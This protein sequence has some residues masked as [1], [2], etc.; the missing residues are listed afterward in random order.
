M[1]WWNTERLGGEYGRLTVV[2]PGWPHVDEELIAQAA[3]MFEMFAV[4]IRASVVPRLQAR[5][6]ALSDV[7]D[8]AGSEAAREEI[9]A[10]A[11]KHEANAASAIDV[12][13]KLRAMESS[14]VKTKIVALIT[15]EQA[16]KDCETIA[17]DTDLSAEAKEALIEARIAGGLADNVRLVSANTFELAGNLG[18][19]PG[20]LGVDGDFQD[21]NKPLVPAEARSQSLNE[22]FT[23]AGPAPS[24]VNAQYSPSK[25]DGGG[26]GSG[27]PTPPTPQA[28][29]AAPLAPQAE[30]PTAA[31]PNNAG[32]I[33]AGSSSAGGGS[34]SGL[35]SSGSSPSP[36]SSM[37]SGSSSSGSGSPGAG[38]Q[39]QVT[40]AAVAGDK[41][42]AGR[43]PAGGI[44]PAPSPSLSAPA[45]AAQPAASPTLSSPT[46]STA[47]PSAPTSPSM[48]GPSGGGF[49]G[50]AATVPAGGAPAAGASPMPLGPPT[51]PTPATPG[52]TP[53]GAPYSP[54]LAQA[55]TQAGSAV[56]AAAAVPVSAARAERDAAVAASTAGAL[57]RRNQGNDPAQLARRIAAALNVGNF[58]F[59]F[60]WV[61]A[62]T[63][64]GTILVA[65]SYGIGYIPANVALP[66]GVQMVSADESIPAQ[67]RAAWATYPILAL[68]GWAQHHNER[69]RGVIATEDQFKGFD[70]GAAK[71]VLQPEDIPEDGTMRGRTRLEVIAPQA[72]AKLAATRD[73]GLAA[74][75]PP[76]QT[77]TDRPEGD[78]AMLWFEV[79]KP[80]MS[81]S[82]SRVQAHLEAFR[83]YADQA[84][85]L[86][87]CTAQTEPET[88][89]QRAAIADWVYWQHQSSVITEAL[90]SAAV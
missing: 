88:S 44:S 56:G 27:S 13:N 1:S 58:D 62:L 63:V 46:T 85:A 10:I 37:G 29:P 36:A 65:N 45:P 34:S 50:A 11:D 61:T 75:L 81:S 54:G 4:H 57:R 49:G 23:G 42:A 26:T 77:A 2:P 18:V 28:A 31:A 69:L 83:I 82:T 73:D 8:G 3:Q 32:S 72:A 20:T 5:M 80:L 24:T 19:S 60:Y 16:Q 78:W 43:S 59:G 76:A 53:A 79:C 22:D 90:E 12:S 21:G 74:L 39:A 41:A 71:I 7:W 14:V 89:A 25:R 70:P 15:A 51:T 68:Q 47:G 40:P 55:P 30:R 9:S 38:G 66:E 87:L 6:M 64:E 33:G 84:M 67:M 52:A 17:S 86:A 48:S 35:S